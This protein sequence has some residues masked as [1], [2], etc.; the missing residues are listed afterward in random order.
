[1]GEDIPADDS[2]SQAFELA[3]QRWQAV[4]IGGLT[5]FP[6]G[7]TIDWFGGTFSKAQNEAVD[8]VVIG[9]ELISMDVIWTTLGQALVFALGASV[10]GN[11]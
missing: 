1:M 11:A 2:F 8:D 5:G 3:A 7:H 10:I 6:K 9:Y 4:I